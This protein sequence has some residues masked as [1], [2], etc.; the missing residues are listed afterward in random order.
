MWLKVPAPANTL[1]KQK[2]TSTTRNT[3][4]QSRCV[5]VR[6]MHCLSFTTSICFVTR[7][8]LFFHSLGSA[9]PYKTFEKHLNMLPPHVACKIYSHANVRL[10]CSNV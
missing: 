10:A 2:A 7:I 4:G 9:F 1:L 8:A 3:L 5:Q 6:L